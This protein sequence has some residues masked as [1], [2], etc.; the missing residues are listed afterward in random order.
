MPATGWK[1]PSLHLVWGCRPLEC[2]KSRVFV[3][4]VTP[5]RKGVKGWLVSKALL[6]VSAILLRALKDDD[7]KGFAN[8]RYSLGRLTP[9]DASVAQFVRRIDELQVSIWSPTH[10]APEGS[11]AGS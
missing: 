7:S 5:E 11:H 6:A 4:L 1:W 10:P 8:M 9:A 2:G 3:F